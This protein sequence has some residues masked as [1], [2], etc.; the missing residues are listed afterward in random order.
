[1]TS[2]PSADGKEFDMKRLLLTSA[3]IGVLAVSLAGPS[4]A[5]SRDTFPLRTLCNPAR[6]LDCGGAGAATKTAPTVRIAPNVTLQVPSLQV[7]RPK[8]TAPA[9]IV[10]PRIDPQRIQPDRTADPK[11]V[12]PRVTVPDF[13]PVLPSR[14]VPDTRA[15]PKTLTTRTLKP[16]FRVILPD[17]TPDRTG[18]A[19]KPGAVTIDDLRQRL[20]KE[21]VPSGG[22][23]RIDPGALPTARPPAP[24]LDPAS[25]QF[26]ADLVALRD[27]AKVAAAAAGLSDGAARD[28]VKV[29]EKTL[30]ASDVRRS[31]E[32]F[33]AGAG[34]PTLDFTRLDL[35]KVLQDGDR[36]VTNT[37]DRMVVENNGALRVLRND[38]VLLNRPGTKMQVFQFK[39]GST[40]N[41]MAYE[42]G[43]K[44]ETIRAG[45]GRV[46]R[47]TSIQA[48]GTE[49]VLFDDTQPSEQVIVNALPE[50]TGPS[51]VAYRSDGSGMTEA[52]GAQST[53]EAGRSFSLAQV[54]DIDAVRQMA[55]GINIDTIHFASGSAAIRP[56]EAEELAALGVAML[57]AIAADPAEVFLIEGHTDAV[58]PDAY[59]L[60]LS[61]RRAESVALALIEYF[62]VPPENMV[63]QG[64]GEA[65]L[66]VAS[67]ASEPANRRAAVRRITPLLGGLSG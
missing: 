35:G 47:R 55:P 27:V 42:D 13:K 59:N 3:A 67:S 53:V 62:G 39:D 20:A 23:V 29:L 43:S 6:G 51:V 54:R 58:G 63:L 28:A 44:V 37:G 34:T 4:A 49:V 9:Q 26:Q 52:L 10:V 56:D 19:I 40:R 32:D 46:M 18:A 33:R 11:P 57:N 14:I 21:L 60:G 22:T 17:A 30:T 24:R 48:D 36:V 64:Y 12:S 65:D 50:I 2:V 45:D 15:A 41:L 1:M 31:S 38:D 5:Q 66:L 8:V 25:S 16:G 7:T 61:D